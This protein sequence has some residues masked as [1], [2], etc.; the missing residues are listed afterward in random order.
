MPTGGAFEGGGGGA[1]CL[2]EAARTRKATNSA[3]AA[4]MQIA[5]PP[6]AF[7]LSIV[8]RSMAIHF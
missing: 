4:S 7:L 8:L 5:T 6:T 1:A 3:R 2:A